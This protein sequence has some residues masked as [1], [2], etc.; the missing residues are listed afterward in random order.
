MGKAKTVK[1]KRLRSPDRNAMMA[2]IADLQKSVSDLHEQLLQQDGRTKEVEIHRDRLFG[3][4][5]AAKM[6]AGIA[7]KSLEESRSHFSD[8]K[9]RLFNS[10]MEVSHLRGVIERVHE[11]DRLGAP[12]TET[13]TRQAPD[14]RPATPGQA[15]LRRPSDFSRPSTDGAAESR[16]RSWMD[17]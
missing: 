17:Y 2:H 4:I 5:A 16:R 10:E 13:V 7:K 11:V 9:E 14:Y 6:D 8:L 12:L 3:D 1:A 15:V